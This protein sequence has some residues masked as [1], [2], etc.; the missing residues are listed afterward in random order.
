MDIH[1]SSQLISLDSSLQP[2]KDQFNDNSH[3]L[4]FLSLLSPT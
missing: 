4:R 2:L 3:L 1:E